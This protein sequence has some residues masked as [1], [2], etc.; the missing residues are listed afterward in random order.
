MCAPCPAP[1]SAPAQ[2][3]ELGHPAAGPTRSSSPGSQAAPLTRPGLAA[4][5]RT[6][7]SATAGPRQQVPLWPGRGPTKSSLHSRVLTTA[8]GLGRADNLRSNAWPAPGWAGGAGRSKKVGGA[9]HIRCAAWKTEG[10]EPE[11]PH[12]ESEVRT[13]LS[14]TMYRG[15]V[16]INYI[17]HFESVL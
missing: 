4:T 7:S 11:S 12:L 1:L 16:I 10:I 14:T 5:V 3:G 15:T 2:M 8:R 9:L 6:A 13:K 17:E